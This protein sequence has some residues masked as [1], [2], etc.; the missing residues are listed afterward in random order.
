MVLTN[1]LKVIINIGID[2]KAVDSEYGLGRSWAL[3]EV[4]FVM[5]GFGLCFEQILW[6]CT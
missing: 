2:H 5:Y 6:S 3:V 1:E 4:H